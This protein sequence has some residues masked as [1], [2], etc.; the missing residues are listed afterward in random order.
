AMRALVGFARVER[1]C[2]GSVEGRERVLSDSAGASARARPMRRV[3][4][5][6]LAEQP[7]AVAPSRENAEI[8]AAGILRLG[9]DR[10]PWTKAVAQWRDRVMFL[11][12]AEGEEWPDVSGAALT[13]EPGWLVAALAAQTG[14]GEL[15]PDELATAFTGL[16]SWDLRR[17]LDA[18]APTHFAAPTGSRVPIDYAA[19][20]GPKISLRVQELFG[21]DRHPAIAGG[22]VPLVV[23]LLSP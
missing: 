2:N 12:Q 17:R 16:L 5:V 21:L 23:E 4:A 3:G 10:L 8:L 7:V 13:A 19:P 18:E 20:E 11:R 15:S 9:L 1:R 22:R 6:V 14:L